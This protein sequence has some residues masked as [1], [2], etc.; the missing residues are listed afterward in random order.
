MLSLLAQ[1][2][3]ENSAIKTRRQGDLRHSHST[4]PVHNK[5]ISGFQALRQA[6]VHVVDLEVSLKDLRK[7]SLSSVPPTPHQPCK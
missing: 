5:V 3:Q 1:V 7:D 4:Q 2:R 6:R